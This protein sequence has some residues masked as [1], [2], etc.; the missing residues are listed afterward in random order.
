M[1]IISCL[2]LGVSTVHYI[3]VCHYH[4]CCKDNLGITHHKS[5]GKIKLLSHQKQGAEQRPSFSSQQRNTFLVASVKHFLSL[6]P[7][8]VMA[9]NAANP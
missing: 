9:A 1:E 5:T 2:A 8:R 7:A 6:S 3:G 4:R